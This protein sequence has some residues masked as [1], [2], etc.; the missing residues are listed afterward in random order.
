MMRDEALASMR[1]K[2]TT[3][4]EAIAKLV[5]VGLRAVG[6]RAVERTWSMGRTIAIRSVVGE[7]TVNGVMSSPLGGYLYPIEYAN[8]IEWRRASSGRRC[9]STMLVA[10]SQEP[11]TSSL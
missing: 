9:A 2:M 7:T 6:L 3:Y 5:D 4:E 10:A 11:L 8:D 1:A